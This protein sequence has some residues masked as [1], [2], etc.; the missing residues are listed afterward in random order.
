MAALQ[1]PID[2]RGGAGNGQRCS[3]ST[4]SPTL[5]SLPVELTPIGVVHS[6]YREKFGIPR[7]PGLVTAATAEL[8]LLPPFD[9]DEALRGLDA[10]SHA[11][12]I[13]LFH[14]AMTGG[15]KPTVRP[16]RLG[17]N[18]RLGVFATRAP[19]RPNPLGLSAV[20]LNGI[21]RADGRLLIRLRGSDLLDGTPVLD[22]KPY[23]PYADSIPGARGGFADHPP[24]PDLSVIFDPA[25]ESVLARIDESRQLRPLIVQ[26]LQLDP[27]PAYRRGEAGKREYGMRLHGFSI[28][29]HIEGHRARV[30]AIQ[31]ADTG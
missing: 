16:P 17:G 26:T 11:W 21:E 20:E 10:F 5:P 12:I 9:R 30:L 6:C 19:Y 25:A 2:G 24:C 4:Q 18:R 3:M 8:E 7:Q 1:P 22:I 29:W 23:L 27:R 31:P 13:F 15:W 14:S 28:R